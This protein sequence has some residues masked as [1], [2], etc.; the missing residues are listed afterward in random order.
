MTSDPLGNHRI[1]LLGIDCQLSDFLGQALA[2][3]LTAACELRERDQRDALGVDLEVPTQMGPRV[4]APEPVGTQ[5]R[6]SSGHPRR[7]LLGDRADLI[8]AGDERTL[9]AGQCPP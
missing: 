5:G 7:N 4:A 1:N 3:E 6:K 9:R 8:G 2:V